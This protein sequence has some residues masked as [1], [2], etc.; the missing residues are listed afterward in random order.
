MC[1]KNLATNTLS[2]GT[3]FFSDATWTNASR[4]FYRLS[5]Q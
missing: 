2:G 4:R 1:L 5:A 3:S